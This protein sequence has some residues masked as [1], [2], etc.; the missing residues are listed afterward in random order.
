MWKIASG[1]TKERLKATQ[2]E[3]NSNKHHQQTTYF[4]F[5]HSDGIS[6][7]LKG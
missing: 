1:F 2:N 3:Q 7:G 6:Y 5:Q 4:R